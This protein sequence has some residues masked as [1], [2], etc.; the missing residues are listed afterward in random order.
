MLRRYSALVALNLLVFQCLFALPLRAQTVPLDPGFDP[1]H[2]LEDSDIFDVTSMSYDYLV[3]FLRS[4]G[5]LA[6]A[7]QTDI[8]GV[9]KP[10]PKIIWRV[11]Q[12]YKINPKYLLALIQKEQSLVEDPAP[13]QRQ[14]D[15]A[16]GYGVCDSCSKDDPA[17]QAFK[18]FAS[19][20]EWS[21]KQYREKYLLQLLGKG[22][23]ISGS[24][25]G[26]PM[27]VD[28]ESITPTNL[29]TAMLYTYTPHIHGNLNLWRIWQ[30]WFSLTYPDGTVVQGKT[31]GKAYLIRLGQKRQFASPVVLQTMVDTNKIVV[32]S[33]TQLAAYPDGPTI[34]FPKFSLL[35]DEKGKIWLLTDEGRRYI[36]NMPAFHKFGFNEDE[37]ED[38]TT[39]DLTD[40]P[41]VEPAITVNTQFPQGVVMQDKVTKKYWYVEDNVRQPLPDKVFLALYFQGRNVKQ[42]TSK[43]L[44]TYILGDT[45]TFHDGELVRG[46]TKSSVYV[47]EAGTL[48]PIPSPEV[49]EAIGWQWR[50]VVTVPD[51]VLKDYTVGDNFTVQS[52][53][54]SASLAT[55]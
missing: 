29:A 26:K 36:S 45:Y 24:A 17:I 3:S 39:A 21:A 27:N 48:H 18:G 53:A 23:T 12:S 9:V 31:S 38:V 42:V 4:K 8:D 14:F 35:K 47:V 41:I 20:L 30:R 44:E 7:T 43:Q 19:Q 55:L 32:V 28:G 22:M 54:P 5:T 50:N 15:W 6:D 2:I 46:K 13:S 25:M 49:F 40:Y 51:A 37:V 1:N 52:A 10:V 34:R 33:D 11:A 16:A